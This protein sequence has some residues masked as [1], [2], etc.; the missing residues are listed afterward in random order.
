MKR[1]SSL[2]LVLILALPVSALAQGWEPAKEAVVDRV[3][4]SIG[5]DAITLHEVRKR[6][7][8]ARNPVAQVFQGDGVDD[9]AGF[10]A[11][12]DDLIAERLLMEE[13]R[14]LGISVTE[15]E[16]DRHVQG[17]ME[18]NGWNPTDFEMAIRMLGYNDPAAYRKHA[19]KELVKGQVLRIKVGSTIRVTDREIEEAFKAAYHGG[20]KEDEIHL[21]HIV[22]RIPEQVSLEQI[23]VLITRAERVR[24]L[25][26]SGQKTFEEA[27]AEFSE[28]GTGVKGGDVGYFSRGTLQPSLESAAFGLKVGELS[29]VVQSSAGFHILRVSEWRQVDLK[30]AEEAKAR[31]RYELT[32]TA[33]QLA[34]KGYIEELRASAHVEVRSPPDK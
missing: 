4:A 21:W 3:V 27:A 32:E 19:R 18:Q 5:K 1:V 7:K 31:V 22:F 8:A 23:N 2:W 30:D 28:D 17:I 25:I 34:L 20:E 29:P 12:L 11:A 24:T 16:V 9:S 13:A 15:L 6:L 33:F 26:N 14:K 10:V